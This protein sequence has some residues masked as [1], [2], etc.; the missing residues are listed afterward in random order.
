VLGKRTV[1]TVHGLDWQREKWGAAARLALKTGAWC[2]A[3]AP[4]RVIVVGQHL[5][6][7][8]RD[9][10]GVDALCI[11]NGVGTI[12]RRALDEAGVEGLAR[13]GYFLF[14][15]RLVPEKG[16]DALIDAAL[17]GAT[18]LV[19]AGSAGTDHA[20]EARLRAR[21]APLVRFVGARFGAERDALLSNAKALVLASTVEGL[22]LTPLEAMAAG[23]PV[24]LSDIA[25]H[26]EILA[27]V[28]AGRL[29]PARAWAGALRSF[30]ALADDEI[31]RLGANGEAHV[32]AAFSWEAAADR[33]A[34]CY[35]EVVALG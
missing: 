20:Y 19:V 23:T 7:H 5:R 15:G 30:A 13:R 3:K 22:P 33:T 28:D 25:P 18:P 16:L 35:R 31:A 17:E 1:V 32:R 9:R 34:A 27:G 24:L 8:F 6:E 10:Y 11:P 26:R 29:V 4:D 12:P 14:L 2:A 21:A